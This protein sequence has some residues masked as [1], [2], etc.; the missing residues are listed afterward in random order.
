MFVV[1]DIILLQSNWYP[2]VT[3]YYHYY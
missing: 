2:S 3:Y 1:R